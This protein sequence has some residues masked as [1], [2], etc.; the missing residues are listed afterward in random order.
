MIDAVE[1][2]QKYEKHIKRKEKEITDPLK[3][4]ANVLRAK[5]SNLF[6]YAT[7]R[8]NKYDISI[9]IDDPIIASLMVLTRGM[10]F[11]INPIRGP[12]I[13]RKFD[14]L[15][16]LIRGTDIIRTSYEGDKI[17]LYFSHPYGMTRGYT[18]RVTYSADR[19]KGLEEIK[20]LFDYFMKSDYFRFL[21]K[22]NDNHGSRQMHDFMVIFERE[23]EFTNEFMDYYLATEVEPGLSINQIFNEFL[24]Y[25]NTEEDDIAD[26]DIMFPEFE[27]DDEDW[28]DDEE[29]WDDDEEDIVIPATGIRLIPQNTAGVIDAA[30][31][32]D[33]EILDADLQARG[34]RLIPLDE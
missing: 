32:E 21:R 6:P 25:M 4:S 11:E 17:F 31:A 23:G 29:D 22:I 2:I 33:L 5:I 20:Q 3:Y 7:V 10:R 26:E 34:F 24:E 15:A 16:N 28:D 14:S 18:L 12:E 30:D 9:R 1:I 27:D 19:M 8:K 13:R